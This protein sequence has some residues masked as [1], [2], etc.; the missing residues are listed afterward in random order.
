[1][2]GFDQPIAENSLRTSCNY[3]RL[4]SQSKVN[5]EPAQNITPVHSTATEG[6]YSFRAEDNPSIRYAAIRNNPMSGMTF[7]RLTR[8][9]YLKEVERWKG[10]N[11]STTSHCGGGVDWHLYPHRIVSLLMLSL[12]NS[13]LAIFELV[14]MK[15][16][17]RREMRLAQD[18]DQVNDLFIL[19]GESHFFYLS[20]TNVGK[21]ILLLCFETVFFFVV[22][23][24]PINSGTSFYS[25]AST[26]WHDNVTFPS[27]T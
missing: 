25:R 24:T 20:G 5:N 2:L 10:I 27:C 3:K 6:V 16:F 15:I 14:Y 1:M 4:Q 19:K 22:N 23:S 21:N 18:D 8:L 26:N 11:S 12:F 9:L 7:G 13:V 17:L